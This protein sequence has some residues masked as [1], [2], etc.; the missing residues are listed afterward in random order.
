M[1]T[2][3]ALC[4][5]LARLLR[6]VDVAAASQ[7]R[8]EATAELKRV[9]EEVA[10]EYAS[11]PEPNGHEEAAAIVA[12]VDDMV[13]LSLHR[14][15]L[16]RVQPTSES[17]VQE[18]AFAALAA[19]LPHCVA[20][21]PL[22]TR[23]EMLQTCVLFLPTPAAAQESATDA[24]LRL[25][26][27]PE[28]LRVSVLT[29][30]EALCRAEPSVVRV[31][32]SSASSDHVHFLAYV[33]SCLL[34]IA[35]HDRCR[36]A[37]RL[38]I[39]VLTCVVD[40]VASVDVLRQFFP[41]ISIGMWKCVD[42]PLQSSK[43]IVGALE[44]LAKAFKRC[45]PSSLTPEPVY[46]LDTLRKLPSEP[47][48]DASTDVVDA[49]QEQSTS[50]IDLLFARLLSSTS[51][52]NT[53]PWSVQC[54]VVALCE[55]VVLACRRSVLATS[56]SRCFE[57]LMVRRVHA[58]V[59][60][61]EAAEAA[62]QQ[63][64]T[65]L[66]VD[67]WLQLE[68]Q[69]TQ[70]FHEHLATLALQCG[71]ELESASVHRMEILIGYLQFLGVARF[72]SALDD[73]L[74]STFLSLARVMAFDVVDIDLLRHETLQIGDKS[75]VV[76]HFQKR[77]QHFHDDATISVA[78]RLLRNVGAVATPALVVETAFTRLQEDES[79]AET[80]VILN[81]C[82]RAHVGE[83]MTN[84]VDVHLVGRLLDDL[85]L[86]PQWTAPQGHVTTVAL[87]IE[88]IGITVEVVGAQFDEFLLYALYP[89]VEKLGARASQIERAA[90]TTLQKVAFV[91]GYG[92]DI[93][94][95]CEANMDYFVDALC[96]RLAHLELYPQTPLVVEGLLRH[97]RIASLPLVD[98][99]TRALLRCVDLYQDDEGH[100]GVLLKALELLIS[101]LTTNEEE[102][103]KKPGGE[104]EEANT[105]S[106]LSRFLQELR[107]WSEP[108]STETG[109]TTETEEIKPRVVEVTS[110]T[111][112]SEESM[113]KRAKAAMPIEYGE[114]DPLEGRDDDGD[115]D[116]ANGGEGESLP[117]LRFQSQVV[118]IL[119]RCSY[120]VTDA[121][122][123]TCCLVLA[124]ME[125]GFVYLEPRRQELL[126]LIHRLW[127]SIIHRL[128]VT[129]RP[130]LTATVRLVTTL[131]Q[132]AGDFI[133]DRFVETVWPPLR[134]I[135]QQMDPNLKDP[136]AS[137]KAV[138]SLT[139]SMLLLSTEGGQEPD[140][141]LSEALTTT[142]PASHRKTQ[143]DRLLEAVLVCLSTV[144]RQ[145]VTVSSL[146]PEMT[147][148]CAVFLSGS[149]PERI[150]MAAH[151]VMDALAKLNGD[152]VFVAMAQRAQWV[153]PQPPSSR[154]PV[155]SAQAIGK[156]SSK[157]KYERDQA[158]LIVARLQRQR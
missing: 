19:V 23:V 157:D 29:C 59:S 40:S 115:A 100:S 105:M 28:E 9:L 27:Q 56:F 8:Q 133:G 82:L 84:G 36:A 119:E 24:T 89:L 3:V 63:L 139:R 26:S 148:V 49:W 38:S 146:V 137:A 147:T 114:S 42:A 13:A 80:L 50:N 141:S 129:N 79:T 150:V 154:F 91:C 109:E 43:V 76:P 103:T 10:A 99:I 149:Q 7:T 60:V 136:R 101:S 75:L 51:K 58:I 98:E 55:T 11:S 73:S 128:S 78:T 18:R 140:T 151:D 107:A 1:E 121:D 53:Q 77:F 52:L 130:I 35:Q 92:D 6:P 126:P 95:L 152:E 37:A 125:R 110:D 142:V 17:S 62:L 94:A 97:T 12:G 22:S 64:Q 104:H 134:S 57:A 155:L 145:C 90:L 5:Q 14:V 86:L 120:F 138:T 16:A 32:S 20:R 102:Q 25:S 117:P 4:A 87:L 30:L 2:R 113:V 112:D 54:A 88:T 122:P 85:L 132:V 45:L 48:S 106:K 93:H 74:A 72:Q 66:P 81:E 61:A 144:C 39:H 156:Y 108:L 65:Q 47:S 15:L 118:E 21:L 67:E 124:T 83:T 153:P 96:A 33:V 68:T 158:A 116:E 70:R 31:L 41:G 123:I 135:L 69:F 34:E 44:C 71:S 127:S 111:E 143:E 131:A 46:S